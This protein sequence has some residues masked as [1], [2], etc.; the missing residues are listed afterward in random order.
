MD[1]FAHTRQ[2]FRAV[3]LLGIVSAGCATASLADGEKA[4]IPPSLIPLPRNPRSMS[5]H[6]RNLNPIFHPIHPRPRKLAPARSPRATFLRLFSLKATRLRLLSPPTLLLPLSH[7]RTLLRLLN[8]KPIVQRPV[9]T[10]VNPSIMLT[11]RVWRAKPGIVFLKT[12][13]GLLSLS[14]KTTLKALPASQ[15]VSFESMKTML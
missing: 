1:R 11:G 15:E 9:P 8:R 14:S 2:L 5:R 10:E 4:Q 7:T 6:R 13:I 12:P 3:F